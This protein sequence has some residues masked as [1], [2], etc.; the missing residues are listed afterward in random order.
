MRSVLVV[1]DAQDKEI[2][3]LVAQRLRELGLVVYG[4]RT[5]IWID[6]S[7]LTRIRHDG[8]IHLFRWIVP[9]VTRASCKSSWVLKDLTRLI[10]NED[11]LPLVILPILEEGCQAPP[12]VLKAAVSRSIDID[13]VD[14][15][16]DALVDRIH[17]IAIRT[18]SAGEVIRLSEMAQEFA[19]EAV[20]GSREKNERLAV[21]LMERL[22]R[23]LS[24]ETSNWHWSGLD[25]VGEQVLEMEDSWP[26]VKLIGFKY[27][28][29]LPQSASMFDFELEHESGAMDEGRLERFIILT[30]RFGRPNPRRFSL[31][32]R[33]V[34]WS[35]S[36]VRFL[37]SNSLV[38]WVDRIRRYVCR[39]LEPAILVLRQ[40]SAKL[41]RIVAANPGQLL[42]LDWR[43]VERLL[44]EVFEGIGFT[45]QL[46]PGSKDGGKDMI[47][48]ISSVDCS[49]VVEVKHWRS[50]KRVGNKVVK[51]F[52]EVVVHERRRLGL[53]LST[54][55]FTAGALKGITTIERQKIR[56]G[57]RDKIL[58]LCKTYRQLQSGV[59]IPLEPLDS[60]L[61]DGVTPH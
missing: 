57:G 38:Q 47:L 24:I 25:F 13:Q 39:P 49:Y 41:A 37:D 10:D 55:G 29:E 23:A 34:D 42:Q 43:D 56:L 27:R 61:L 21:G 26:M 8:V 36:S 22:F 45:V 19:A 46:T 33:S 16:I 59:W 32:L 58:C 3:D 48:G 60:I 28:H 20:R 50:G 51:D 14:D 6:G 54:S 44:A 31:M 18:A 11:K 9:L 35:E 12:Q 53:L 40:T 17:P 4:D 15:L 2:G 1:Y 5:H 52:L 7:L 30:N